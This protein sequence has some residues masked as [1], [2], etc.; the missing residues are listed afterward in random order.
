M[1]LSLIF[2]V[3]K[4]RKEKKER[5]LEK[6]IE[7]K[8]LEKQ[9]RSIKKQ[10]YDKMMTSVAFTDLRSPSIRRHIVQNRKKRQTQMREKMRMNMII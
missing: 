3:K 5:N 6:K 7:K 8:V 10:S 1:L 9:Q 4:K 2:H